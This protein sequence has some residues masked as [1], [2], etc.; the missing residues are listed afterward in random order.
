MPSVVPPTASSSS[1][2]SR[3]NS[4]S[5][6]TR[7][8]SLQ[9][10]QV[11]SLSITFTLAYEPS[12]SLL[13]NPNLPT[14]NTPSSSSSSTFNPAARITATTAL[15]PHNSK[16]S[17]G[18]RRKQNRKAA[19]HVPSTHS[20]QVSSAS[21][22]EDGGDEDS[23]TAV[24]SDHVLSGQGMTHLLPQRREEGEG[25]ARAGGARPH[26]ATLLS[27]G[28]AV[29]VNGSPWRS[30]AAHVGEGVDEAVVVVYGLR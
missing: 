11:T 18:R 14:T 29:T 13:P 30:V 27:R 24:E 20:N 15:T 26:F 1:A 4:I 6:W 10:L 22:G 5:P 3:W 12:S 19:Q 23:T 21:E 25:S 9:I 2:L 16:S 28:L 17:R 7:Q 8:L